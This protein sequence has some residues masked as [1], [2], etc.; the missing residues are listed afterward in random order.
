MAISKLTSWTPWCI[1]A[2]HSILFGCDG[3]VAIA[4][5]G[6]LYCRKKAREI[7]AIKRGIGCK[8][9][10]ETNGRERAKIVK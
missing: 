4:T 7:G 6:C 8:E 3:R 1:E 10:R 9:T 2:S 5:S